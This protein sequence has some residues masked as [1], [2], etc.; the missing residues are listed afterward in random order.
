MEIR[1]DAQRGAAWTAPGTGELIFPRTALPRH[2]VVESGAI[3]YH[4][5]SGSFGGYLE[6][7]LSHGL[8]DPART[9][10]GDGASKEARLLANVG[11]PNYPLYADRQYD[12]DA[13]SIPPLVGG[14]VP[15][16]RG[17][18][19]KIIAPGGFIGIKWSTATS[20]DAV[21]V[22]ASL[23]YVEC[24]TLEEALAIAAALR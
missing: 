17:C 2:L 20:T 9:L 22:T 18:R 10:L 7:Y 24:E 21:Q 13:V 12:L 16:S 23:C 3:S 1:R 5:V 8:T 4:V 19:G 14:Y 11:D 15:L 6:L